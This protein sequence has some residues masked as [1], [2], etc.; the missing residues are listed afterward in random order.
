VLAQSRRPAADA[1]EGDGAR[2]DRD[3]VDLYGHLDLADV[4]RD[5]A[6]V[7]KS[8]HSKGRVDAG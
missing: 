4:A 1:L 2:L 8:V 5:L 7:E 3:D 6:C